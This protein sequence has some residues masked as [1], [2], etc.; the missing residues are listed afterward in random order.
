[1]HGRIQATNTFLFV[2]LVRAVSFPS[3]SNP[4]NYF[5]GWLVFRGDDLA[6]VATFIA[7][8]KLLSFNFN[9]STFVLVIS[10][11]FVML[12]FKATLELSMFR[13]RIIFFSAFG[14]FSSRNRSSANLKWLSFR[15]SMLRPRCS[16][17]SL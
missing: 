12:I 8:F 14:F 13:A 1:M 10:F 7:I 3:I 16:Q 5:L 15:P 17:S 4:L 6:Q 2:F 11:V 9:A